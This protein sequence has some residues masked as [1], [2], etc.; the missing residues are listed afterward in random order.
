LIL[1]KSFLPSP[2]GVKIFGKRTVDSC[3]FVVSSGLAT[4]SLVEVELFRI[5]GSCCS[6]FCGPFSVTISLFIL[7]L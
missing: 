1:K 3:S 7:L 5:I 4:I 6:I 2:F